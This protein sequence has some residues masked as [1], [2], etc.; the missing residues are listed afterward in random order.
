VGIGVADVS[1]RRLIEK[2]DLG[3]M[4]T[5]AITATIL[6]PAK[7]PVVMNSDKEAIAVALKTCNRITPDT[8][9][10][11]RIINTLE[12]HRI[13]VS[14]ALL[15]DVKNNKNLSVDG[16]KSAMLFDSSGRIQAAG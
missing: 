9:R 4:Y 13:W 15:E 7:L 10:I 2:L 11:V 16:G 3:A 5:N 14:P 12:L 1:T 8:V 6:G